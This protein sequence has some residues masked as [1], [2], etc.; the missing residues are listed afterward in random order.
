MHSSRIRTAR[1]LTVSRSIGGVRAQGVY[2]CPGV[3][4]GVT[5]VCPRGQ[6]VCAWG[7]CIP[8]EACTPP[9]PLRKE[10]LTHACENI[11]FPQL[12]LQAVNILSFCLPQLL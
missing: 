1:S 2:A 11:T 9:T 8:K 12:L 4:V 10:S 3:G 6:G 5:R 7:A